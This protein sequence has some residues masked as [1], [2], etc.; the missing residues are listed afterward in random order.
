MVH[1][2]HQVRRIWSSRGPHSA[3][4]GSSQL[5]TVRVAVAQ[6]EPV[7]LDLEGSVSKTNHLIADA[8]NGGAK[9]VSFPEVW[10]PGYPAWLWYENNFLICEESG[11]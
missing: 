7:W 10:I 5:P 4:M 11:H 1:M 9:L 2:Q 6:A 8:A 3:T